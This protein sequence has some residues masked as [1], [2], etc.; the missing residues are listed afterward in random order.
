MFVSQQNLQFFQNDV[1]TIHIRML[2]LGY[3][4]ITLP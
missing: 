3:K 2:E 1:K 4:L